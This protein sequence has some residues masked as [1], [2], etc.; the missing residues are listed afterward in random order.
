MINIEK[1]VAEIQ[2]I[3]NFLK[4]LK[5][6]GWKVLMAIFVLINILRVNI[7]LV[8]IN[9]SETAISEIYVSEIS[10]LGFV[11]LSMIILR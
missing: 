8:V 5:K 7:V 6:N 2:D 11:L 4:W 3:K 10:I 9:I 1:A